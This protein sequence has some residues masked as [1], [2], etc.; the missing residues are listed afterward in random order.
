M[1]RV[2]LEDIRPRAQMALEKSPVHE[3]RLLHVEACAQGLMISGSV[4]SFYHKQLAQEAVRAI[5]EG[6]DIDLVNSIRVGRVDA[7]DLEFR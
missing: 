5:C 7:F 4:S 1:G 6:I 2:S 3:L